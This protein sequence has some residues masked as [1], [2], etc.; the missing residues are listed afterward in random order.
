[1]FEVQNK[2]SG[3]ESEFWCSSWKNNRIVTGSLDGNIR[4]WDNDLVL[5]KQLSASP[6]GLVSVATDGIHV[7]STSLDGK[8]K[9]WNIETE[10]MKEKNVGCGD[11]W[12]VKWQPSSS[13]LAYSTQDGCIVQ[14]DA[15]DLE[16]PL[17]TY[18]GQSSSFVTTIAFSPDGK[19]VAAGNKN[20]V[21]SIFDVIGGNEITHIEGHHS[22]IRCLAFSY[23]NTIL[24]GADDKSIN[25]F[26]SM[27]G[28]KLGSL[29]G[30]SGWVLGIACS[31]NGSHIASCS[32]DKTIKIWATAD[33]SC[34]T[35]LHHH[36]HQVV[37]LEWSAFGDFLTS[38]SQDQSIISYR[39]ISK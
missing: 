17:T 25:I 4:V 6:L 24:S 14:V 37:S 32:T 22:P 13:M 20:G 29:I 11:V 34:L 3:V 9:V 23:N 5:L 30:H 33:K 19:Y 35:T 10:A 39:C 16:T 27:T 8:L 38:I 31:P 18:K 26:D 15:S 12:Q 28:K 1:M 21:I 7:A 2:I 36:T